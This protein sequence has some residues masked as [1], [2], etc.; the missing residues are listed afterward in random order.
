M[1]AGQDALP[2]AT[3]QLSQHADRTGR[4]IHAGQHIA[5]SHNAR[6]CRH[7]APTATIHHLNI[8]AGYGA[9][10]IENTSHYQAALI[11]FNFQAK[12]GGDADGD[13]EREWRLFSTCLCRASSSN[14]RL[15]GND[16]A[17]VDG[18]C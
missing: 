15:L 9:R 6:V 13:V 2:L 3:R 18:G 10:G 14:L 17:G 16:E 8:P 7:I 4:C 12:V 1:Y 5:L 11:R